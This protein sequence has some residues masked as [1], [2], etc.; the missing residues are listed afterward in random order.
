MV[1]EPTSTRTIEITM[2]TM[3]RLMKNLD[4]QLPPLRFRREWRGVHLHTRPHL[5]NSFGHDGIAFVQTVRNHPLVTREI[6]NFDRA[7][8]DLISPIHNRYLV[9][10]LQLRHRALWNE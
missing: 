3:G 2:A 10:S 5:L 1:S 4:I 8:A 9:A 6:P 7:D